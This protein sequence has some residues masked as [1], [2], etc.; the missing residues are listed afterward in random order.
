[1]IRQLRKRVP[2]VC[3][4]AETGAVIALEPSFNGAWDGGSP[5]E[6]TVHGD[7]LALV[8]TPVTKLIARAVGSSNDELAAAAREVA[9]ETAFVTSH[10]VS[11]CGF[12]LERVGDR[13]PGR[14]CHQGG[15]T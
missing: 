14:R 3:F 11:R 8:A 9:G 2:G 6:D 1:M 5:P 13:D 10:V 4:A 15:S 7:A 12:C